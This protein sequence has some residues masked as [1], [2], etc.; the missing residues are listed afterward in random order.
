MSMAAVKNAGETR[1]RLTQEF[2]EIFLEHYPMIYRTAYSI[3]GSKPDAEDVLQTI[4]LR[5]LQRDVPVEFKR[6]PKAYLYRAAVNLALNTIRSRKSRRFIEDFDRLEAPPAAA[7]QDT[8]TT[9]DEEIQRSLLHAIAQLRPKAVE[10][11]ILHYEHNYSDAEI[12]KMLGKSRGTI[13]VTLYRARA[14]LKKLMGR[15]QEKGKL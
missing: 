10:I 4:F 8:S 13:A 12:A 1:Q 15:A 7:A 3:T 5:L 9:E 6:S 11:L 14:R 2:T